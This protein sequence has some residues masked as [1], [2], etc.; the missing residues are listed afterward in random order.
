MGEGPLQMS[1]EERL[2]DYL[3]RTTADLRE[4]RRQLADVVREHTGEP[5]AIVGMA[6]RYPGGVVSPDDLWRLV[7]GGI[8][9]VADFPADRGWDVERLYDPEP[10]VP[11]R[12]ST[13]NGA[14]L[15]DPG[16]FDAP[17]FGI[18]P[19]EAL[20]MDPQQRLLL[21][22]SWEALERARIDPAGL[23]G[24][25]TGVF[26]GLMY[27]DYADAQGTGSVASGR[28][29]YVFGF[30]GPCVTIDTACSSSLVAVHLAVRSLRS[31]ESTFAL[32]GGAALMATPATFVEFSKQRALAPD[33]RCKSFAQA[34]DG[35]GWGEGVG[36]LALERL[37]DAQR[38]GHPVVA[39]IRGTATNQDGA[40][41]GL[42]APN[43]RSQRRLIAAA[44]ADA[45]LTAADVDAV[46][47]HGTGT[48]L[49]DPIEAQAL[50]AAYGHDRAQ[51]LWLGS[52]KSNIGHT[53][54][55]AGVGGMIKM[56]E[57]MRN[58]VL[59]RTL[60]VDEPSRHVDWSAGDVRL[61]T[62]ARPWP[63]TG[64]PRRAAVS[65]F[66][67]SGTNAHVVLEQA[68]AV[69]DAPA[70]IGTV[71]G[72]IAWPV[73]AHDPA[74]L[75]EQAQRLLPQARS[76]APADLSWSLATAR[77]ELAHR[78]VL[79]G[80]DRDEL[81][82]ELGALARAGAETAPATTGRAVFVFPGQGSQWAGMAVELLDA[83]T[84]GPAAAFAARI[85]ECSAAL[86]PYVD[87]DLEAVLRGAQAAPD[88]SRVDVV[89]PALWAVMVALAAAW[90]SAG[91]EPAAVV[92]HSQGEIAAACVAGALSLEDGARVVAMRSALIATELAGQGGMMSVALPAAQA[93]ER[94]APWGA[95]LCLA[96]GNGPRATV[97]CGEV[98]AL[99][100]LHAALVGDGVEARM[101][102]VDYAS[103]SP[104]VEAIREPL[105]RALAP[106][107]PRRAEI[108]F[109]STVKAE[110]VDTATL[111]A[112][113]WYTNLRSPVRFEDTTR[114]LLADGFDV[115]VECSPHPVLRMGLTETVEAA[116]AVAG[117]V[118]S[119]RRDD[120]GPRRFLRSLSDAWACGATVDW[121]RLHSAPG[122]GVDLPTYPFQ[123][124][125]FWLDSTAGSADRATVVAGLGQLPI[126]HPLLGAL[127]PVADDDG[128]LLTGRLGL[129]ANPWLADHDALGVVLLPGT[130]FVELAQRAGVEAGCDLLDELTL[131]APLVLGHDIDGS[132]SNDVT[133]QV[134]VG[135]A[136]ADG[137]RPVTV[138]S[139][140][141]LDLP[142]T[143]HAVG[144][145]RAGAP[146]AAFDLVQ[147]PPTGAEPVAVADAY[148]RLL[149]RGYAYGPVF[150]G[151][152]A[153]WRVGTTLYAEV[154]L[155]EQ[156]HTDAARFGLHPAALDAALHA[157]LL[158]DDQH[159]D[160]V[161]LP[162]SWTGMRT[163]ATGATALR[164]RITPVGDGVSVE[165]ADGSGAP[166][167]AVSSLVGRAVAAAQLTPVGG[168]GPLRTVLR[169]LPAPGGVPAD[170]LRLGSA[171][172]PSPGA[173]CAQVVAL[174]CPAGTGPVPARLRSVA[175]AVAHAVAAFVDDPRFAASRLV[176]VTD[177]TAD[178]AH[179]GV[180]GLVRA[181]QAESPDRIVLLDGPVSDD[182]AD[183]AAAAA[184]GEPELLL[185]DGTLHVARLARTE[186]AGTRPRLNPAATVVVTGGTGGLGALAARHLVT[187]HGARHLL[188]LSRRGPAAPGAAELAAELTELG[189]AVDVVACDI[190]DR[191]ALAAALAGRQIT[192]V[193]HAAGVLDDGVLASL[194]PDRFATVL[195]PKA[196]A[197]W[198]L[199]ELTAGQDL[200]LFALYSS[201]AGSLGS[202]G[203][204]NYA[205][206][207][208]FLDG[209][210]RLRRT[211]G[212]PATSL[213][214]G[215]WA[216]TGMG[217]SL[218]DNDIARL[219]RAGLPALT[220]TDG[221]A[222]FDAAVATDEPCQ[223]LVHL[224]VAAMRASGTV[225]PLLRD[226][227]RVPARAAAARSA[228][229]A[230]L[231][232]LPEAERATLLLDLVRSAVAGVLGHAGADDVPPTTALRELGFDSLTALELRNRL[233]AELGLRLPTTLVFDYPT[234]RVMAEFLAGVVTGIE[235]APAPHPAAAG[236][237]AGAAEP[238]AIIAMACRYPGGIATPEDLWEVVAGG[239]DTT[240]PFPTNRGWDLDGLYDP[241]PGTPGRSYAR[242]GGF[243]DDAGAFDAEF[244]AISP[245]EARETDPQQRLLLETTWELFERAGIDATALRGSDTGVFTGA[246]YH[247]YPLN[248]SSGSINS[249]RV[250]YSY[251]FQGPAITV[252]TACSSSLVALHLAA[253]SLRAGECTLAVAGGVTVM[254]TPGT[255]VEF[256]MQRGLSP[257][258]RC[259]SF[260]AGADG[261]GF[262]EGVGLLLVERLSDARRLGHPVL[263]VLRGSA[264]NQ[265]GA[266]NGLTAPNGPAQQRVIR[267]ALA[268]AGLAA[269][270]VDAVEAHG[271]GTML[272]DPIEAGAL[273]ATYGRDRE[274]P[275]RLGSV[276]SNIGHTQAAAGVAGVLKMVQALR[277]ELLPPT[278]HAQPPTAQ[279]DWSAG[280]VELLQEPLAWPRNGR[281]RRAAVSSFGIGG[282]NAHVV[283]EEGDPVAAPPLPSGRV[284]PLLLSARSPQAVRDQA[285]RLAAALS[286][287]P[288]DAAAR[289]LATTRARFEHC[290]V[291]VAT[292]AEQAR[293]A[294][295]AVEP[296][297]RVA[298]RTAF[299]FTGQGAQWAGMGAGLAAAYP[300]FAEAIVAAGGGD[301][302]PVDET[303]HAQ[304]ALF[305]FEVALYRLLESWG[306]VPD[307][308][309]GHSVGEIAAAHVA[310]VLSLADARTLVEARG[311]LM[312]AL[313][314]GGAMVALAVSRD[315]VAACLTAGV[316]VA[317][318]NGPRSVVVSGV[319]GEVL[320]VRELFAD[321]K[322]TRLVVS[323]AFHSPLMEPMLAGFRS[324]VEGL[325]FAR[326]RV[327]VVSTLTGGRLD[328]FDAEH[329]VRHVREPVR[330]ADAVAALA[331][332]GVTRFVEIGPDTVLST[333]AQQTAEGAFIALQRRGRDQEHGDDEERALVGGLGA[334]A[335]AGVD[336]DWPAFFGPTGGHVELPTY[337]F[338]HDEYWLDAVGPGDVAALGQV[339]TVHPVLS[340]VVSL[341]DATVLTGRII[342]PWAAE[343]A[344]AALVELALHAAA[345]VDAASVA[346]LSV[347]GAVTGPW[348]R[349]VR[350]VVD[351]SDGS[352]AMAV[353][354][355]S[356]PVR[357]SATWT[358]HATGVHDASTHPAPDITG[359]AEQLDVPEPT[360]HAVA[361]GLLAAAARHGRP[362]GD[363]LVAT[364]WR[365]VILHGPVTTEPAGTVDVRTSDAV[366]GGRA[367]LLTAS[368]STL[369]LSVDS[370]AFSAGDATGPATGA[371]LSLDWVP[372]TVPARPTG[373][374]VAIGD[375]G[376]LGLPRYRDLDALGVAV[377]GGD[378]S[379]DLVV[380]D[381]GTPSGDLVSGAR[382]AASAALALVREWLADARFVGSRLVL[383]TH[384]AR[385]DPRHAP[386]WGIARSAEA[387]HPGR[388]VVLDLAD[389]ASWSAVPAALRT[390]E[391]E[392]AV[393][394]GAVRVPRLVPDQGLA[395]PVALTGTVL[396][397][398]APPVLV[399]HLRDVRGLDVLIASHTDDLAAVIGDRTVT[400]VV[401]VADHAVS[402]IVT[403][404][405]D[406]ALDA[407]LNAGAEA[408]WRLHE[409]VAGLPL[410]AFVVVSTSAGLL[411]GAGRA[412]EAATCGFLGALAAHRTSL[413][414]PTTWLAFGPWDT[415][416][417][418]ERLVRGSTAL[419]TPV[420]PLVDGLALFDAAVGAPALVPIRLDLPA[421]R[422]R[423]TDDVPPVLR[424]MVPGRKPTRD[425]LRARLSGLSGVERAATLLEVITLHAAA[426]LGHDSTTAVDPDRALHDLGFDSLA[427]VEFR[428]RLGRVSGLALT[429][430][431]V[432][433]HPTTRQVAEFVGALLEPA[434]V[435]PEST[436][437]TEVDRL[438]AVLSAVGAAAGGA[439]RVTARLEA[440]LRKWMDATGVVQEPV[441]SAD[442]G[443]ATDDE[444]FAVLD[445]ELGSSSRG[446]RH[447]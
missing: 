175:A 373:P 443:S 397:V 277:H 386:I 445:G 71:A 33:G 266:S 281:P 226:L 444:L 252:D 99:A 215:L 395:E 41:S 181:V 347:T 416:D 295:A 67:V 354:I 296:A 247:D 24:S 268:D 317:A 173:D 18:S 392:L 19:R 437:V 364:R 260:G 74:A 261:T 225:A 178:V 105:A 104:Y 92:G 206:A 230:Q 235:Q 285:D 223:V 37:S 327:P 135:T 378:P 14:F 318:V 151:L 219:R 171:G 53:Q 328:V 101:V 147:W 398:G 379:P 361:P 218:D 157:T 187:G 70:E 355:H 403:E 423:H 68:P 196:D 275:V 243:L 201:I 209:L 340:A 387:E 193:V 13:R 144:T 170:V 30:E 121:T 415:G 400:A 336:V 21:E 406:E 348:P 341:P 126:D 298:G 111:D 335:V 315:E 25:A 292:D 419:G 331:A 411:H 11:G 148:D 233:A 118:G 83:A 217:T 87:W 270:D 322:A 253:R 267:A 310:G 93:C 66:G 52:L 138:H 129:R 237:G 301:F 50:I 128:L 330:F 200:V 269:A 311:R 434:A 38:L 320:A 303:G 106:V 299:L 278:L 420:L 323:H 55:A 410:A 84:P 240:G 293:S 349:N 98:G 73:S 141:G 377:D 22:T 346:E 164:V 241:E 356:R 100:E 306:V 221:L 27:L 319:E 422:R 334:A 273:V 80:E 163:Y 402:T 4:T 115:F 207:N 76:I 436:M 421:L 276:K 64:R 124:E 183:I 431:L 34:A 245:K 179:A 145:V 62:E 344:P 158:A 329:W 280:A 119:L 367:V 89:Q 214:W 36:M 271:T 10:G 339:P 272:G 162:F 177:E 127:A 130:A 49:G 212:L 153:S 54:S 58:G 154:V 283:I 425:D 258:G 123:H 85:A 137:A 288:L 365:G 69:S 75:R 232:G 149:R 342:E 325:S 429:A 78:A 242:E 413:G 360:G 343:D 205:T 139:R 380:A 430:T 1:N 369:L 282:T 220:A 88:P 174:V 155:P 345:T 192:G 94:M 65:S 297:A 180:S 140:T 45:R 300:V 6:C 417:T 433:D 167:L 426:V 304:R 81:L 284:V 114:A 198:H 405:S 47:A 29:S 122:R 313:P 190:A 97:V 227:V 95:R 324:V 409:A 197:A 150:Q 262:A 250:A 236:A 256:S 203:Q 46:E 244:F 332:D 194:T 116:G 146:A 357:S 169:P 440:L 216:G 7:D 265:D 309:A 56:V 370:V 112:G 228:I 110:P 333:I 12:S 195:G 394:G 338:Q 358:A 143:R 184:S 290:A 263:A 382:A 255:L 418:N 40:S 432:F 161:V 60:H 231:A 134:R 109:Y 399:E 188:L 77:A 254:A 428:K 20:A 305:A 172:L 16:A 59:P 385:L 376:P 353:R 166:V 17:F 401:H 57:A 238:V 368:D 404:L 152:R 8:D 350:V 224:D 136:D 371:A 393:G 446:D 308:V 239:I 125:R 312:Q 381:C 438:D 189:A 28:V 337:P 159:G 63:E 168:Q 142:W 352:G 103:H 435:D 35:T 15:R 234:A 210:A 107:R 213:A 441:P 389:D 133:L 102:P 294:L 185:R 388:L 117:V 48:R 72:P 279:V 384:N 321:R 264:V 316:S 257:D 82:A 307:F 286:G 204:A 61:L 442:L 2:L 39:V 374:V 44:L 287:Q 26:T 23:K 412:V 259:R 408:A 9:A 120:G 291:V 51:P 202:A 32:A 383:V 131:L 390:A 79:I 424:G 3:K 351:A 86:A 414:L 31:G 211:Q 289:A 372:V 249:G 199:H 375:T 96:A 42:T 314:V 165:V 182:D 248:S 363:A 391:P 5:I 132:A 359:P 160:G 191:D 407:G 222:L 108:A 274:H 91:V 186:A 447:V 43:G 156:A 366:D 427:A 246:M 439:A 302:G 362:D 90:R 326:P 251:G 113:Y 176:V 208:A 396:A 229:S